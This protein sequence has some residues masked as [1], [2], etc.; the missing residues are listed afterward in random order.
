MIGILTVF[1]EKW[2]KGKPHHQNILFQSTLCL[3]V[4]NEKLKDSKEV[5]L[6]SFV[7]FRNR[8][9]KRTTFG[10]FSTKVSSLSLKVSQKEHVCF[11]PLLTKWS[12]HK[13]SI[14]EISIFIQ[15]CN[16]FNLELLLQ[17]TQNIKMHKLI[18]KI[19]KD[20]ELAVLVPRRRLRNHTSISVHWRSSRSSLTVNMF[21]NLTMPPIARESIPF[22]R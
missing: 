5:G 21:S 3:F 6:E 1:W 19:S 20:E 9:F 4:G 12:H 14:S 15:L 22:R 7:D 8:L 13:S 17:L 10:S 11:L 16:A 2:E 18:V